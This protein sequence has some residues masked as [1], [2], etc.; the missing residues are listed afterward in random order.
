MENKRKQKKNA[1]CKSTNPSINRNL[2]YSAKQKKTKKNSINISLFH[3][4]W[5]FF[6]FR[7]PK[8]RFKLSNCF[9]F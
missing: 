9:K 8:T 1:K 7:E 3:L 4:F 6:A 5:Q 2:K